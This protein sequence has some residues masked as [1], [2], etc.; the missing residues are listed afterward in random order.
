MTR[1][2]H[3]TC[4][5]GLESVLEEE[6]KAIGALHVRPLRGGVSFHGDLPLGYRACMWLRSASR[7]M[8]RLIRD[9]PAG[10]RQQLYDAVYGF[11]WKGVIDPDLTFS[12]KATS[13][14]SAQTDARFLALVT[15]DALV[16]KIRDTHGNRPDV[17][18]SDPDVPI[19]LVVRNNRASLFRDLTGG[20]LHRRGW[21][22][23]QVKSPLNEA[24]AAGL[25]LRAGWDPSLL[26][27]DPMCGSGTFLIEAAHIARDRA[28]GIDQA[29]VF[30]RWRDLDDDA[31]QKIRSEAVERAEA[32]RHVRVLL[33]GSDN[34]AGAIAIAKKSAARAGVADTIMFEQR[35]VAD[36]DHGV[37]IG[38]VVSNPPWGVRIQQDDHGPSWSALGTFLKHKAEGATAWLLSGS[39]EV[40]KELRLRASEKVPVRIGPIDARWLRYE[41]YAASKR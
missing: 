35:D 40:T 33:R 5:R 4:T 19:R 20:S 26:T 17:D 3:A 22:P 25:L 27:V 2:F 41:L 23:I 8:E 31:W 15:K 11:D 10:S 12:V 39:P 34:H 13:S 38:M 6:L 29:P 24:I 28:P 9:R 7:V 21:R 32:G 18:A 16:D 14:E 30:E 1:A 36:L 37:P